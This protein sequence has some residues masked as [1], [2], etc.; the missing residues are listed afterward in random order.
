MGMISGGSSASSSPSSSGSAVVATSPH[1]VPQKLP[2]V[3]LQERQPRLSS[4]HKEI[5]LTSV[6][7]TGDL[8]RVT[9]ENEPSDVAIEEE[10]AGAT[11]G[12]FH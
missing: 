10:V 2:A 12:V 6:T 3:L 1:Q 4:S 9:V 8:P 7:C 5:D 11:E